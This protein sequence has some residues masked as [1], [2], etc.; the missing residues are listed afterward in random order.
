MEGDTIT[1]AKDR[2]SLGKAEGDKVACSL[3]QPPGSALNK[4]VQFRKNYSICIM[5]PFL[6]TNLRLHGGS[7]GSE[8]Q[9]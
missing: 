3:L 2:L 9:F 6:T 4:I 1:N 8:V 5:Y 7:Q